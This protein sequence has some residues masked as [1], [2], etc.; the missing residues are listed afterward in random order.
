MIARHVRILIKAREVGG[1]IADNQELARYL[2]VHPFFA[3]NYAA[4]ARNFSAQ[5]LRRFFQ[6]LARCDRSL[7]CNTNLM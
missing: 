6:V 3:K 5:E 7:P 1:R 4:Q 2:G